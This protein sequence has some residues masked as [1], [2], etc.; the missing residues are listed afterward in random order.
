M[1]MRGIEMTSC[2]T[3]AA[4]VPF[5]MSPPRNG[6]WPRSHDSASTMHATIYNMRD[7]LCLL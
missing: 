3:G 2:R 4:T 5:V 7:V 6:Q 1:L